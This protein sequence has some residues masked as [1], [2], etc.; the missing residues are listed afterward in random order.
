MGVVPD[1]SI[2]TGRGQTEE[3]MV[4]TGSQ[5][6]LTNLIYMLMIPFVLLAIMELAGCLLVAALGLLGMLELI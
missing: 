2:D 4:G 3:K 5:P 6:R 1:I